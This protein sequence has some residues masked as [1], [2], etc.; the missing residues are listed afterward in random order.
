MNNNLTNKAGIQSE[1]A[2]AIPMTSAG[3][4]SAAVVDAVRVQ[5][6]ESVTLS[7]SQQLSFYYGEYFRGIMF[8]LATTFFI[9]V[10]PAF[11]VKPA[12]LRTMLNKVA[13]RTIDIVGS[14]VGLILTLPL[15]IIIPILIKL[16]SPG[17]VFY[18]Q[19]RVG[20]NKRNG[21]R[22]FC[23]RTDV[24]DRRERG[25]RRFD[26]NGQVFKMY[27][28]RT[29]ASGAEETTGPVLA[30]END[31]R[32]TALGKIL[33]KSRIDEIP[34]FLNILLGQMSLVGPRPER[35]QFVS[36]YNEK[37]DNY[38]DRLNAKPGLTGLAQVESGYDTSDED[39][40]IKLRWDLKY[41][42]NRS[43]LLDIK[44]LFR[45]VIV[46]LTGRGAC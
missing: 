25:R 40:L 23:Q 6:T 37:Y 4:G 3:Y 45:T 27:K 38:C 36:K 14:I 10:V 33:R 39:V 31:P 24:D 8:V 2:V 22:R 20:Q 32:K 41:I 34:Q 35:P 21:D 43:L 28:F 17:D 11:M 13:K 7:H 26:N 29:M 46:V 30:T 18:I 9:L 5:R 12:R 19:R 1:S 16:D 42:E 44:I 15:W